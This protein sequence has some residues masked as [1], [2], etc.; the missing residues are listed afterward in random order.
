[1]KSNIYRK[2][3]LN[4]LLF[5]TKK[6]KYTNT[7]K[8]SKLL[9]F[10][11]FIHFKQTGYPSIGLEYYTFPK[12]PVPRHF[13]IEIKDGIVPEDFKGKFSLL[14]TIDEY[15]PEFKEVGFIAGKTAD[16]SIFT[17]RE[18]KILEEL[19][20]I[21]KDVRAGEIPEISHLDNEPWAITM[22]REGEYKPI[23]YMLALDK[24]ATVD[25]EEAKQ[26]LK[27]YFEVIKNFSLEPTQK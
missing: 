22:K 20:F 23:D 12:G 21:F 2:K 24:N 26:S 14:V 25:K 10:F 9:C 4:A 5:F 3:L 7:T 13:W 16:L 15:N 18:K 6:T 11:D 19:V 1:M 17:P 8:I 27:E